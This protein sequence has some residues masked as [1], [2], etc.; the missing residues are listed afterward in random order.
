MAAP[1]RPHGGAGRQ[2]RGVEAQVGTDIVAER[3]QDP[4]H[5]G[6]MQTARVKGHEGFSALECGNS[7][8]SS[9]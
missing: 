7:E 3:G 9:D 6:H 1:K 8:L 5:A 2:R 4:E